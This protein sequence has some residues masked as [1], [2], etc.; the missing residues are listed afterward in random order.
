LLNCA[1]NHAWE[2]KL[3]VA[4][5]PQNSS[6]LLILNSI[7][8]ELAAAEKHRSAAT[9]SGAQIFEYLVGRIDPATHPRDLSVGQQLAL[10]LAIQ[11]SKKARLVLLDEPTRGLDADTKSRLIRL[12]QSLRSE[13]RMI[14]VAT[15]DLEFAARIS[16]HQIELVEGTVTD[17]K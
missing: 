8:A 12:L 5:V 4:M 11:L 16:D 17:E 10:A 15:H 3:P 14:L 1:L 13:G 2:K 7:S 6:D 9:A